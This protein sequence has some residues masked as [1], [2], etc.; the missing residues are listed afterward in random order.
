MTIFMD[1]DLK[2][3]MPRNAL[4]PLNEVAGMPLDVAGK[5]Q[6]ELQCGNDGGCQLALA[7]QF[8]NR[9]RRRSHLSEDHVEHGIL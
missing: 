2:T 3:V 9:D 1:T 6:F 5:F 4:A 7:Q 8:V